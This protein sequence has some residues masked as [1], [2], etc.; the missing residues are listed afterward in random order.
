MQRVYLLLLPFVMVFS[1]GCGS[2]APPPAPEM[3]DDVRQAI[4]EEDERVYAEEL[5]QSGN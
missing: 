5:L 3:T 4:Q 1:I 2:K